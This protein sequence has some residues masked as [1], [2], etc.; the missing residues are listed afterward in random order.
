MEKTGHTSLDGVRSYKRTS[1]TQQQCLSDIL[2]ANSISKSVNTDL[3]SADKLALVPSVSVNPGSENGENHGGA[4]VCNI[5]NQSNN[6]LAMHV[7]Q[8]PS[9]AFHSCSVIINNNY[10]NQPM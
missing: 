1:S 9:F 8:P 4:L 6:S 3:Q 7:S 10:G 2:N 5:N